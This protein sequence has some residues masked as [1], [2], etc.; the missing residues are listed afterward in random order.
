MERGSGGRGVTLSGAA[1][2]GSSG[3][4]ARQQGVA[5]GGSPH[6]NR[7][8]R[9]SRDS[10]DGVKRTPQVAQSN[11]SELPAALP[12][13][14]HCRRSARPTTASEQAGAMHS[15]RSCPQRA[16]NATSA[17]ELEGG[18]LGLLAHRALG[19]R[20]QRRQLLGAA[21]LERGLRERTGGGGQG[22]RAWGA[23][24]QCTV[25]QAAALNRRRQAG[26]HSAAATAGSSRQAAIAA[27]ST[28]AGLTSSSCSYAAFCSKVEGAGAAAWA[29]A[30]PPCSAGAEAAEGRVPGARIRMRAG[31]A[32]SGGSCERNSEGWGRAARVQCRLQLDVQERHHHKRCSRRAHVRPYGGAAVQT[33]AAAAARHPPAPLAPPPVPSAHQHQRHAGHGRHGGLGGLLERRR[34]DDGAGGPGGAAGSARRGARPEGRGGGLHRRCGA[35]GAFE[36]WARPARRC[37]GLGRTLPGAESALVRDRGGDGRGSAPHAPGQGGQVGLRIAPTAPPAA[38][39]ARLQALHRACEPERH[40]PGPCGARRRP[41]TLSRARAPLRAAGGGGTASLPQDTSH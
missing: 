7:R 30:T 14:M 16:A 19:R 15:Q 35:S 12:V 31:G 17:P 29:G 28:T 24:R 20:A 10:C 37:W 9:D 8:C 3:A 2:V 36:Q 1:A 22:V 25:A 38:P 26:R 33:T 23:V 18:H 21:R 34:A 11:S 27:P 39:L 5:K 41:R 4:G 13:A 32:S 6:F 40:R